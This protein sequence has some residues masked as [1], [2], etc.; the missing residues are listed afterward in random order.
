[1]LK[2]FKRF[3]E[4]AIGFN[5]KR[6][7]LVGDNETGKSTLITAIELVISGSRA[8]VETIGLDNIFNKTAIDE[9]FN[10]R[11]SFE[12][13]P[14]L[15]IELYFSGVNDEFFSGMNNSARHEEE[16][17]RLRCSPDENLLADITTILRS[18]GRQFPFEYYK[19]EFETFGGSFYGGSKKPLKCVLI[20]TSVN[21]QEYANREYVRSMYESISQPLQRA[22]LSFQYR[23]AKREFAEVNLQTVNQREDYAFG[24]R[25][26]SKSNLD[27]DLT[28]LENG[29]SI[30]YKGKGKQCF[31]K[32]EFALARSNGG[33]DAV[34]IEE[35]ENHLSHRNMR[36]LISSIENAT[37]RQLII[38][39]HSPYI[40]S[41]L[42]LRNVQIL[43]ERSEAPTTLNDLPLKV[44]KF[45]MKAPDNNILDFILSDR[46][47]LVEGDAEYILA[48]VL[49]SHIM[50]SALNRI[51][52]ISV[53]G[54]G[55]KNYL[56]VAK[57]TKA[58][59]A[60]IRDNDGDHESTCVNNYAEYLGQKIRIFY[61][62]NDARSTFEICLYQDNRN[63][64]EELFGT[65]RR[66]LDVQGY[67]LKNKTE[68][69]FDLLNQR[70]D[71]IVAPSYF[72]E[73]IQWLSE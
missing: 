58:K 32:A 14:I 21:N 54:T 51:H 10:G 3:K 53:N 71:L 48:E 64:C 26:N 35:P 28:V 24:L 42:D 27:A 46:V 36:R 41:R 59:V 6:N 65:S 70:E 52:V 55:F 5:E 63:L 8:R 33:Q 66:T 1:M 15:E 73:A 29:I 25:N 19:I 62:S 9:F 45:F 39:T 60:V 18:E 69:A 61:D 7:L 2:N 22:N 30:D 34:L 4:F 68:A 72:T 20:D 56:E 43:S 12:R 38:T 37:E 16:G 31:I 50:P 49:I 47:L 67:M 17:I 11:K 13:L 57:L 40:S 23:E 44:A